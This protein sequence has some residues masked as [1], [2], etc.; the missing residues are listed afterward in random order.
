M[1]T[2]WARVVGE[3]GDEGFMSWIVKFEGSVET[4]CGVSGASIQIGS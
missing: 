2:F 1:L 3:L 4:D